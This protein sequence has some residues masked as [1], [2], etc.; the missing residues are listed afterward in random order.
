MAPPLGRAARVSAPAGAPGDEVPHDDPGV[1]RRTA[2]NTVANVGGTVVM[3]VTGFVMTPVILGYLGAG[4]YGLWAVLGAMAGYGALLDLGIAAAV[5]KYV[6]EY[7][8]RG[9][10]DALARMVS[11]AAALYVALGVLAL[12]VF[13]ALAP[14]VPSVLNVPAAQ[15]DVAVDLTR[16]VGVA[17]AVSI[18]AVLTTAILRGVQRFGPANL[19][20]VTGT[21]LGAL[22][23]V[24]VIV[25][26][27][28]I[29]WL[30]AVA[31][32]ITVLTQIPAVVLV[33][34]AL[35]GLVLNVRWVT[36][37]EALHLLSY[38]WSL[39]VGQAVGQ[40]HGKTDEIVIGA[41][42]PVADVTPYAVARRLSD[43]PQLLSAQFTKTLL[44]IAS[45]AHA[46]DG[47]RLTAVYVVGLRVSLA[48]FIPVGLVAAVFAGPIL[49]VW[50]GGEHA[51]ATLVVQILVLA[52]LLDTTLWPA[53]AV[54][55]GMNRHR[56]LAA[57]TAAS[58]VMNLVLS[59][60]LVGPYGATGV[61]VGTLIPTLVEVAL[62]VTPL[63]LRALG[64]RLTDVL[65][66]SVLPFVIPTLLAA[67]VAAGAR[68]VMGTPSLVTVAA[69]ALAVCAVFAAA[70]LASPGGRTERGMVMNVVRT[71]RN[72]VGAG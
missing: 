9:D 3:M 46:V 23:A 22:A 57:A 6:A 55:Q 58:G 44:P 64:C 68:W 29:L 5:T 4:L 12:L 18:P 15:R 26:D 40:L 38:S 71:A 34:R 63:T 54:L 43:V 51:T 61:A 14:V 72:R 11:T 27:A 33:R 47:G 41:R 37:R 50:V 16:V 19:I 62:V 67:A 20:A 21:V 13:A 49:T 36:F 53:A 45:S 24:A 35:P 70:F 48:L 69:A 65:R 42:L 1:R 56:L 66:G 32:P 17:V 25:R 2:L 30:A 39:F 10:H 31:V 8:A 59:L 60:A 7:R 28:G 52:G